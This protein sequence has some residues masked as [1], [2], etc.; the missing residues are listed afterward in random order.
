MAPDVPAIAEFIPGF[1]F[2]PIIGIYARTG[3]PPAIL[4]KIASEVAAIVKEPEIIKQFATAASSPRRRPRRVR[5]RAQGRGR[6]RR[7]D[8]QGGRHDAA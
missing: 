2:A 4:E 5:G 8:C 3:T 6:A 7:Q 1:Q